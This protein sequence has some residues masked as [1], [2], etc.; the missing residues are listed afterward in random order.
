MHKGALPRWFSSKESACQYNRQTFDTWSGR[1][2]QVTEQL[3]LCATT[4]EPKCHNYSSLL[5]LE[6]VLSNK[7]SRRNK[8]VHGNQRSSPHL[9]QLEKSTLSNKDPEQS[10]TKKIIL[11]GNNKK[12]MVGREWTWTDI[13]P[14]MM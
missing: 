9:P 14:E 1:I 8:T 4:F 10:K 3:S 2:P 6:P 7:R 11:K 12:G 13:S 5:A